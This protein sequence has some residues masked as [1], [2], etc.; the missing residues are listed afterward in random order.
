MCTY[1]FVYKVISMLTFFAY[2]PKCT[3]FQIN[4]AIADAVS[5]AGL[6]FTGKDDKGERMEIV[7]LHQ[8]VL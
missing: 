4:P 2:A 3:H 6:H 5:E 1:V 7:E 8:Q